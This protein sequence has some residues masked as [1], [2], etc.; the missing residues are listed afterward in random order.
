MTNLLCEMYVSAAKSILSPDFT[1]EEAKKVIRELSNKK[2]PGL[3]KIT[4]EILKNAG[5]GLVV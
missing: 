1:L 5:E 2:A 4:N 3:D